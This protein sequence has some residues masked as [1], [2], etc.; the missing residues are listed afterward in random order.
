MVTSFVLYLLKMIHKLTDL[1]MESLIEEKL[2]IK[3]LAEED[4]PREKLMLKGRHSLSDAELL[5]IILGSGSRKLSAIEVAQLLLNKGNND[6]NNLAQFTLED[7]KSINGI[8]DAKAISIIAALELGRRRKESKKEKRTKITCSKD[9]FEF[10]APYLLDL[11]HEELWV[12]ILT[13]SNHIKSVEKVSMG[14]MTG[15]VA[16]PKIVFQ[17]ALSHQGCS[18]ILIHNHPSGQV[19]PSQADIML[20]KKIK[21]G[22]KFLE[23]PLLDHIV[24]GNDI[25]FSFADEG[26]L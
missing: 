25:Y 18:I 15:T 13:R 21:E 11:N 9:I 14:G 16:D 1:T 26:I 24:F 7:L 20:T 12:I 3:N 8:G 10:I 2:T 19:K 23:I 17:K 22:G 5:A 6:L 4:R